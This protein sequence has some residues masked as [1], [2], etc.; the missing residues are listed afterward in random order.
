[1]RIEETKIH[2]ARTLRECIAYVV[3]D[4]D[5]AGFHEAAYHLRRAMEEL[6]KPD[7]KPLRSAAT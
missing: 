7:A 2:M 4:C 6:E 1:M 3:R 5:E